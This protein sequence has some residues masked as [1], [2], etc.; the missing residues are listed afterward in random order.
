MTESN[1]GS[2]LQD[3]L[4]FVEEDLKSKGI[5]Q[6]IKAQLR[7]EV[8]HSLEDKTTELPEKPKDVFIMAELFKEFLMKFNLNCTLSVFCDEMGCNSQMSV[9]REF[10]ANEL[11]LNVMDCSD[12]IPLL[13]L[14]IQ[15]LQREQKKRLQSL[16][17]TLQVQ[18]S[19]DGNS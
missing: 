10:I 8:Y 18:H 13:L 14:V 4:A 16:S 12:R 19:I 11:G 15:Y 5:Y 2:N 3:L 9:D 7:A 6:K 1:P 17:D